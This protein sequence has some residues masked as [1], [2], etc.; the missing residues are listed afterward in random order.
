MDVKRHFAKIAHWIPEDEAEQFQE[1]MKSCVEAGH[2]WKLNDAFLYYDPQDKRI[3]YGVA[4]YGMDEPMDVLSLFIGIFTFEDTDTC[5]M[6]FKL[7]EG[8]FMQEYKSLLT[9][10]SM[11]R[12][13][14]N[15]EHPLMIRIDDL[16]NRMIDLLADK[17]VIRI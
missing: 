15:P 3:S 10:V 6:R 7:H 4:L 11:K 17:K 1:R 14:H 8:K 2:A 13:H 9:I 16:R 12:T 5:I